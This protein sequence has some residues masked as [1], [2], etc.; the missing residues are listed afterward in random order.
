[1]RV[2]GAFGLFSGLGQMVVFEVRADWGSWGLG[3]GAFGRVYAFL[4]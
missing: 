2:F 4:I 3:L 1:M